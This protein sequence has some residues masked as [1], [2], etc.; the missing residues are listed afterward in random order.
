MLFYGTKT[1]WNMLTKEEKYKLIMRYIDDIEMKK[2]IVLENKTKLILD[3]LS[4]LNLISYLKRIF[5]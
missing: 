2:I 5:R 3:L 4:G 1:N